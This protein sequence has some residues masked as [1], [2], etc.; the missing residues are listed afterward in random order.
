MKLITFTQGG[1]TRIGLA[2][3][4][5]VVDLSN[6]LLPT[7]M[8][9]FLEAGEDAW[10]EARGL[11][12]DGAIDFAMADVKLEAPITNP[13]KIL[14]IG[15]NYGDHI[16]ESGMEAPKHQTWFNK[17]WNAINGPYDDFDIPEIAPRLIDYEAELCFVI[18]KR[19]RNVPAERAA[20]VIFGYCCGNDVSVRDWQFRSQTMMMGKSWQTHAPIGPWLI[21]AD[22]LGDPHVLDIRCWV[23]GE[24][25]QHSNTKHLIYDCFEQVAELSTAFELH[26]GDVIFSGTPSG[27]GIAMKPPKSLQDGDVVRIEIEG[28]GAIENRAVNAPTATIIE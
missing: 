17:Q 6:T 14:A 28:I 2:R 22:E 12:E 27:V 13:G 26:P 21:T 20:E 11:N 18:G 16:A 24:E 3:D 1:N 10:A 4:D 19:C 25:R 7:D 15:L 9:S 8:R 23:N 5:G